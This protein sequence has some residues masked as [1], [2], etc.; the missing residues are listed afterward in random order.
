[1]NS[2]NPNG[3]GDVPVYSTF[4]VTK[5][6]QDD[7][8]AKSISFSVSRMF[9]ALAFRTWDAAFVISDAI[10]QDERLRCTCHVMFVLTVSAC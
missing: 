3:D 5:T 4:F 1:M 8:D 9:S 10:V 6:P 2:L 7:D